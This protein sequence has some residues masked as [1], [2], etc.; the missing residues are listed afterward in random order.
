MGKEIVGSI[1]LG[2]AIQIVANVG[3][4]VGIV[5][6]AIELRQN[7]KLMAAGR[8]ATLVAQT[9][10]IWRTLLE[11]PDVAASL[12]RDRDGEALTREE[13]FRLNA[14]WLRGLYNGQYA[15]QEAPSEMAGIATGWRRAFAHYG[16]LERTWNGDGRGSVIAAKD[17]FHA[18]FVRFVDKEVISE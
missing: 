12:L 17:I 10:D 3:V 6:L 15:F 14:L 11:Q 1:D 13:E 2:Q 7:N 4:L 5:L 16:S 8:R 18:D 9:T